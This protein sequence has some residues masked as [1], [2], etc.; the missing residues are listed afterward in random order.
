MD[1]S[2]KKQNY[3]NGKL[4]VVREVQ[5][6]NSSGSRIQSLDLLRGFALLGILIM[7]IISFSHIGEGYLNPTVGAGIEGYNGSIHGFGFL[8]AD[9]RFMS[10]FSILFGAGVILFSDNAINKNKKVVQLHY[11]RMSLLFLFGLI[12]AYFIWMGDILVAYAIC[13]S[14]VFLLRKKTNRTL[15]II[16]S[17][18]FFVPVLLNVMTYYFTPQEVLAE[19]FSFWMPTQETMDAEIKAYLGGFRDQNSVRIPS[20]IELQTIVFFMSIMWRA[21]SMM[22]LGMIL[23]RSG[24]LSATKDNSY[25]KKLIWMGFSIGLSISGLGLY[26]AYQRNWEGIWYLNLGSNFN[27]VGSLFVALAYI[28]MVMIWSKTELLSGLQ[29]RLRAVGRLAFTNYILTSLICT[30]IFYGHGL[31]LYATFDRL[32]QW[33]IVLLVWLILLIISPLILRKYRQG[34]LE[35]LWRRL[36]Y[37]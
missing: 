37:L 34:P 8:F 4:A 20:A 27:Y 2:K 6:N 32:Q 5:N 26:L 25:Y 24:V 23:Y 30:F 10:L 36:T 19:V 11:R 13:G 33:G 7:N 12:H 29:A 16:G 22:I 35:W 18:L 9:T 15:Y 1:E 17:I 31:G 21:L 28:G 3:L 14:I